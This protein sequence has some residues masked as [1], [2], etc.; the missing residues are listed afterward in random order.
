MELSNNPVNFDA[1]AS[2][3]PCACLCVG[4]GTGKV[5]SHQSTSAPQSRRAEF[6]Q[7][8]VDIG[9]AFSVQLAPIGQAGGRRR[10]VSSGYSP[11]LTGGRASN[12]QEV[13]L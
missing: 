6:T 4:V 12:E 11:F 10:L 3:V 8:A 1:R 7:V 5:R 9:L 2:T 13:T